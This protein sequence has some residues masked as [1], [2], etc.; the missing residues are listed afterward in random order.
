MGMGAPAQTTSGSGSSQPISTLGWE[1][2]A[3]IW[4]QC[5]SSQP[6][7]VGAPMQLCMDTSGVQWGLPPRLAGS[8]RQCQWKLPYKVYGSSR[9]CVKMSGGSIQGIGWELPQVGWE[10]L[11]HIELFSEFKI[12]NVMAPPRVQQTVATG[13]QNHPKDPPQGQIKQADSTGECP[14]KPPTMVQQMGATGAQ[15]HP[16]NAPQGRIKQAERTPRVQQTGAVGAQNRQKNP[17]CGGQMG[18]PMPQ[19]PM[20]APRK[21]GQ[22][23]LP[24]SLGWKLPPV[25]EPHYSSDPLRVVISGRSNHPMT[26][27]RCP[28]ENACNLEL[29]GRIAKEWEREDEARFESSKTDLLHIVPGRADLSQVAVRF[30]GKLIV[31]SDSV[32]WVGLW[33]DKNLNGTKHIAA[34]SATALRVLNAAQHMGIATTVNPADYGVSSFLP[35]PPASFKP[36]DRINKSVTRCIMSAFRT[37]ALAVLEKEAALLPA[38]LRIERDALNMVA[39]YLTLPPSHT[40]H[41]LIRDVIASAPRS[42]KF[43]SILH[44]VEHVPC[45]NWPTTVP[46]RGQCLRKRGVARIVGEGESPSADFDATLGMEP[47]TPV[48]AAP[49]STPLPVTTVILPKDD[50]LA[51][52][53]VALADE[54]R[55]KATWFTDGSLLKGS[56]GGAAVRVEAGKKCEQI[57]VP[58]G[59]G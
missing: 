17:P 49:W 24:D 38:Q 22:R 32:K 5:G 45:T 46:A 9:W 27:S 40:I 55:S 8:S 51:A 6:C 44:L 25:W 52:L 31:Q 54:R 34:R 41:A 47:I 33:L 18:A 4:A 14:N 16:K 53:E 43:A 7:G 39:F 23:K 15:N 50:A 13:T 58:L 2:P 21:P 42:P 26:A 29:A 59:D 3:S 36:L 30:D 37:T 12:Q 1:L 20:G 11:Q 56:A 35:L 57:C 48:Y 28:L 10:L 19:K